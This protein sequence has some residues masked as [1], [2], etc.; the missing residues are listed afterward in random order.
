[1][2]EAQSVEKWLAQRISEIKFRM[3]QVAYTAIHNSAKVK[4]NWTNDTEL[5]E[6]DYNAGIEASRSHVA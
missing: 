6:D 4:M 2:P 5:S 3:E 1:M